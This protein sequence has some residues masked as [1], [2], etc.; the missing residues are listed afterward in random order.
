MSKRLSEELKNFIVSDYLSGVT[1]REIIKKHK[2]YELYSILKERNIEY[3]QNNDAQKEKCK[4][5]IDLYHQGEKIL[6]K[7]LMGGLNAMKLTP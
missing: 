2:T 3:K 5:V 7:L 4:I 6:I 1:T